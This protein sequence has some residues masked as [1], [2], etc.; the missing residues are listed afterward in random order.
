MPVIEAWSSVWSS[1]AGA[2]GG[3]LDRDVADRVRMLV[4]PSASERALRDE[5]EVLSRCLL[6]RGPHQRAAEAVAREL[7]GHAGVHQHETVAVSVIRQL[8][9]DAVDDGFEPPRLGVVDDRGLVAH[10]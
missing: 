6:D 8:G 3:R 7:V 2:G 9:H 5:D 1:R 10:C 4:D